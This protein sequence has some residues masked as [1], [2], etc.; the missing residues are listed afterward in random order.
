MH[1]EGA[2]GAQGVTIRA[3]F[4]EAKEAHKWPSM[5]GEEGG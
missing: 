3:C 2:G 5:L 1:A 4:V